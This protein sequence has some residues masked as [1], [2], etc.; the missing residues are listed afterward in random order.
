MTTRLIPATS[1]ETDLE[2]VLTR[3]HGH[4][5][6]ALLEDPEATAD[7]AQAGLALA[8]AEWSSANLLCALRR[9]LVQ[10]RTPWVPAADGAA[11]RLVLELSLLEE[12]SERSGGDWCSRPELFRGLLARHGL[13]TAA[14]DAFVARLRA[15]ERL[16]LAFDLSGLPGAAVGAAQQWHAVCERGWAH[17]IAAAYAALR[18]ALPPR[19]FVEH[20]RARL[21]ERPER[22]ALQHPLLE[23]CASP[24]G[25]GAAQLAERLFKARPDGAQE[26]RDA[27]L[28]AL[29]A[30]ETVFDRSVLQASRRR[31]ERSATRL[32]A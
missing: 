2:P 18:L 14:Y 20:C 13:P 23:L 30:L 8:L 26:A 9:A 25:L 11:S 19:G 7:R 10:S 21:A 28:A 29:V 24:A 3:L 1:L 15:G 6:W 16:R 5:L 27:A 22:T 12:G 4:E 32:C 17:E 31:T